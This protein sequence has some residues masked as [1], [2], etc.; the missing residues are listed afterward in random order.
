M[1]TTK[2]LPTARL[3]IYEQY[4]IDIQT[5]QA[6]MFREQ[7]LQNHPYLKIIQRL[8]PAQ[9]IVL[10]CLEYTKLR[11]CLKCDVIH[12]TL[13][14]QHIILNSL[15][16]FNYC[17]KIQMDDFCNYYTTEGVMKICSV[18]TYPYGKSGFFNLCLCLPECEE[19]K[20]IQKDLCIQ[21]S[22]NNT[23][24]TICP[25]FVIIVTNPLDLLQL[26]VSNHLSHLLGNTTLQWIHPQ[27][28]QQKLD[29]I[30][31]VS[32]ILKTIINTLKNTRDSSVPWFT[33]GF[34]VVNNFP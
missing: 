20:K 3:S 29:T 16:S 2:I 21:V 26:N 19:D 22:T 9:E 6:K 17:K 10:L 24:L 30:D 33:R 18:K 27:V 13:K 1:M 4:A 12:S 34:Y 23:S 25:Y 5:S 32:S 7:W 14:C 15:N 11:Y 31:D 8:V 28:F